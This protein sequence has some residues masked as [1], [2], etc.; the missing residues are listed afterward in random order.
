MKTTAYVTHPD[1][2]LHD[3]GWA[4][5]EHQGRLAAISRAVYRDMLTLHEPLLEVE[6]EPASAE[7]LLLAHS[8]EYVERVR[9]AAEEAERIGAVQPFGAA[10]RISG[11]SWD[12]ARAAAGCG[13][14]AVDV[15]LDGAVRN[16]FC[17]VRP[18]GNEVG[19]DGGR[20][21]GLFNTAAIAAVH[22]SERRELARVL[23]VEL[24]SAAGWGTGEIAARRSRIRFATV[25][26]QPAANGGWPDGTTALALQPGAGAG[27]AI[28]MLERALPDVQAATPPDLIVLS[29]GLDALASDP[30]GGL[31]IEPRSVHDLT[32]LVRRRADELCGGRLVSVLEGGYDASASG[33]AVVQHLRALAGLEPA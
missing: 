2:S 16:A 32:V 7:D 23:I 14:A 20:G 4:H 26:E 24:V 9:R 6:P 17:A 33:S 29:L 1:C 21:Y 3:T 10:A 31:C 15:V 19:V 25:H 18:P 11:R 8:A 5:P 13:I 30:I 27:E 22:A 28:R 12:A